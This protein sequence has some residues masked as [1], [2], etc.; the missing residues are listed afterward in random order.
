MDKVEAIT[1][2]DEQKLVCKLH[3]SIIYRM[4][5]YIMYIH[6]RIVLIEAQLSR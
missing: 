3:L 2:N 6:G 1:N 4:Y 5:M